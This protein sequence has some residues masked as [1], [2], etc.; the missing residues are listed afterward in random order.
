MMRKTIDK[1]YSGTKAADDDTDEDYDK[2]LPLVL[3]PV[4]TED[5]RDEG[6]GF[7]SRKH[8]TKNPSSVVAPSSWG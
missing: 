1:R 8:P 6:G 2:W 5:A 3:V 7:D 4:N